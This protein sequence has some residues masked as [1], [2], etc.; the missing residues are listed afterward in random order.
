MT[1]APSN[2]SVGSI[3]VPVPSPLPEPPEHEAK[4]GSIEVGDRGGGGIPALDG[5][6]PGKKD[7]PIYELHVHANYS[8]FYGGANEAQAVD[9]PKNSYQILTLLL[10]IIIY[11]N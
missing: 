8:F 5:S 10:E 4:K 9:I 7:T 11:Q 3:D 2:I 1:S 6:K